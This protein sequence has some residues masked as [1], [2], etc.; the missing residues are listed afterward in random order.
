MHHIL[1]VD[2][3]Q[4]MLDFIVDALQPTHLTISTFTSAKEA[5]LFLQDHPVDLIILDYQMPILSGLEMCKQLRRMP[6]TASTPI[7][8]L[9]S[10]DTF[11]AHTVAQLAG[12]NAFIEKIRLR[13]LLRSTVTDLLKRE[14]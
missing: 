11:D 2:D 5:L 7:I 6:H 9:S 3:E 13:Q 10:W 8:F 4:E 1:A 12:A 14:E